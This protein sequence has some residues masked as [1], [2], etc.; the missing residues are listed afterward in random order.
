VDGIIHLLVWLR[1][2]LH[3]FVNNPKKLTGSPFTHQRYHIVAWFI[4]DICTSVL[5]DE[6][7]SRFPNDD[8]PRRRTP[9]NAVRLSYLAEGK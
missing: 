9:E 7:L 4:H 1:G 5:S 8:D 6:I 2:D 3:H